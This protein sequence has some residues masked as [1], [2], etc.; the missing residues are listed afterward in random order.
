MPGTSQP[1][2]TQNFLDSLIPYASFCQK[3]VS[4]EAWPVTREMNSVCDWEAR[5]VGACM[6]ITV[7]ALSRWAVS[8]LR[9]TTSARHTQFNR[10]GF[11]DV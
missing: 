11:S 4:L 1:P 3:L 8:S 10:R 5:S 6:D 7:G 9:D 2:D